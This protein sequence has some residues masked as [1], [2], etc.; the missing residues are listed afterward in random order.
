MDALLFDLGGVVIEVDF[1]RIFKAWASA[2]S[3][4]TAQLAARFTFDAHYEAHERGAIELHEYCEHLR[5]ALGLAL[6]DEELLAGWNR[7]FGAP[8]PGM[9]ALLE[10]LA[11]LHPLYVFSNTNRAHMA[12]WEP[13]YR[14]LLAPFSAVYCSCDLGMRKP[15]VEAFL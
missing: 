10:R 2:A 1:D 6:S 3:L 12:H 4:P 14:A 15:D 13:R 5:S 11:R 7:I 9:Q 8:V